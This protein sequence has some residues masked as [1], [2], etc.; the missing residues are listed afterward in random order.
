MDLGLVFAFWGVSAALACTP[1]A[2]WAY[3]IAAALKNRSPIPAILG[4]L[5][6]H[7]LVILVVAAG[8]GIVITGLP[9]LLTLMTVLGSLYLMWLGFGMIRRPPEI[10]RGEA[11]MGDSVTGQVAKGFAISGLNPKVFLLIL[12]ILPQFTNATMPVPVGVQMLVIGVVHLI[13]TVIVY[14]A[15]GYFA[16]ALLRTR[17]GAAR[18]VSYL[19]GGLMILIGGFMLVERLF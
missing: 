16:R 9:W 11:A 12:V 19:S 18:I 14:S 3:T 15:V 2:D 4:M 17:P 10:R 7:L 8:V 5:G 1:G 6:G 13:N